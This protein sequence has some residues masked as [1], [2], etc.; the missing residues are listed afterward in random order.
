MKTLG[1]LLLLSWVFL[2]AEPGWAKEVS[3]EALLL[4]ASPEQTLNLKGDLETELNRILSA[5][6]SAEAAFLSAKVEWSAAARKTLASSETPL[7]LSKDSPLIV[8]IQHLCELYICK[9][10]LR[11]GRLQ[12]RS[13]MEDAE[14]ESR[15]YRMSPALLAFIL[16]EPLREG[17]DLS[18]VIQNG[19]LFKKMDQRLEA[20]SLRLMDGDKDGS[21]LVLQGESSAH[22]RFQAQITLLIGKVLEADLDQRTIRK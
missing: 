2:L 15:E 16:G 19:A 7:V 20:M 14:F 22:D 11:D 8:S 4:S 13:V 10:R 17:A 18:E 5:L 6:P 3:L 1:S 21:R 9:T 12:I